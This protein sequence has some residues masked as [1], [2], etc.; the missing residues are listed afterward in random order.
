MHSTQQPEPEPGEPA[1]PDPSR[2][3]RTRDDLLS[4]SELRQK[5]RAAGG[6]DSERTAA[7]GTIVPRPSQVAA[8]SQQLLGQALPRPR[9]PIVH[10][11]PVLKLL[12]LGDSQVGKSQLLLRYA[13]GPSAPAAIPTSTIGIDHRLC[14]RS[15]GPIIWGQKLG[16]L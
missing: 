15:S 5:H 6:P 10:A 16:S 3:D 13:E 9:A 8:A 14:V 4:L 1:A 7:A 11:N 2:F 12:F